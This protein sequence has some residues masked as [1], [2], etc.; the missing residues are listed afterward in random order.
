MGMQQTL[1][2]FNNEWYELQA[3]NKLNEDLIGSVPDIYLRN[4]VRSSRSRS[5]APG[6]AR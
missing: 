3:S 5:R 4:Q 6:R 2:T 1:D